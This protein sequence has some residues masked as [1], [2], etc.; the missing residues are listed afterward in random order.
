MEIVTNPGIATCGISEIAVMEGNGVTIC[1]V[2]I[3]CVGVNSGVEVFVFCPTKVG[4]EVKVCVGVIGVKV[5]ASVGV[6]VIVNVGAIVAVD[7]IPK[8]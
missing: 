5:G 4:V 3:N 7:G 6:F 8:N 1:G 2:K